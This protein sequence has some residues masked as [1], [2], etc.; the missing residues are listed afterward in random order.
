MWRNHARGMYKNFSFIVTLRMKC[1]IIYKIGCDFLCSFASFHRERR[2][3]A[4]LFGMLSTDNFDKM[5]A[6]CSENGKS[7]CLRAIIF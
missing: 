7:V 5:G 1:G 3:I 4:A 6:K 2:G